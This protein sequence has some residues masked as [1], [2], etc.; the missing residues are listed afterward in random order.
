MESGMKVVAWK[1]L[2]D[3]TRQVFTKVGVPEEDAEAEARV[4]LWA[5]LRAVDSHGV[6][7]IPLYLDYIEKGAMN[8]KP[9]MAIK[10]VSWEML[11]V[12]HY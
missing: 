9:D 1:L 10:S 4:L 3:F 2:H 11:T 8:P 12:G 7:R 5:N 6:L